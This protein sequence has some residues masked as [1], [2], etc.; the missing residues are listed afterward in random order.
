MNENKILSRDRLR[1]R[2]E[3]WRR[4]GE[5]ITLTNGCFDLLH[6]GHI[7]YLRGAKQLG[8]R[9]VVAI[10]SDESVRRLKGAGRPLMPAAERAEI[11]AALADVDA[12][13]IFSEPDVRALIRELRPDIHAKGTDYTLENVPERDTVLECGGSVAIVGDPKGHSA[14]E[15]I[16]RIAGK[17]RP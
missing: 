7:R 12:V 10:N 14:T 2:A 13:V 17:E 16:A 9:L 11:V 15:F 5:R 4:N 6:V 8:G 1:R 3:E